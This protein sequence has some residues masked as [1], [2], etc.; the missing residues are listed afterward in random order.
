MGA[1]LHCSKGIFTF[2]S[3]WEHRPLSFK[4]PRWGCFPGRTVTSESQILLKPGSVFWVCCLLG[5]GKAGRVVITSD[6][7]QVLHLLPNPYQP[8]RKVSSPLSDQKT[9]PQEDSLLS[10]G[11]CNWSWIL[12]G[13]CWTWTSASHLVSL[14]SLAPSH[15]P[16]WSL[17]SQVKEQ[18]S[19]KHPLQI[20]TGPTLPQ[21]G[22]HPPTPALSPPRVGSL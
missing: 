9:S 21:P 10:K 15:W 3:S 11:T 20:F 7:A 16:H 22:P 2:D 14:S 1:V 17:V 18:P 13:L 4:K 6:T 12:V 19:L 8:A 5:P